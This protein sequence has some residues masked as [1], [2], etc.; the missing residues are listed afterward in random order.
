MDLEKE[1]FI[2]A[3]FSTNL[4][5]FVFYRVLMMSLKISLSQGIKTTICD[6]E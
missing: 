3:H 2:T 1:I 5:Y 6:S 4:I